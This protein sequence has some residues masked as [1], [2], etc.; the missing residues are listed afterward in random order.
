MASTE[1][2]RD[3]YLGRIH[4][5]TQFTLVGNTLNATN[6][7]ATTVTASGY[8]GGS[9]VGTTVSGTVAQFT[10]V[11]GST[12][13]GST[14]LFTTLTASQAFVSG[15]LSVGDYIQMLP[16]GNIAIP[17]NQT[18]SYIYTS[19]STNDIYFTQ[20][21]PG[22]NLTNTT[23]LR[24]LEGS[25]ST[26]LLHGGT[27]STVNG[28]T[29]FNV[30]SGSG[31]IVSYNAST[32]TDPYPTIKYI[33]W[34][35]FVSQSLIYS[36]SAQI[37]YVAIDEFGA[38]SQLN[39]AFTTA[40]FK[41]RIILGRVLHQ[42]GSVTNGTIS[43]PTTAYAISSNTQDFFRAFGPLKVSGQILAAS[44]S[45]LGLTRTAGDSYVEGRNYSA[46]PNSPNFILAA[47][48]PALTTT[49]IF[50]EWVSGSTVNIDTNGGVGYTAVKPAFYNLNGT[51]TAISPTN[52][53]YTVQRVYWFPKSV[54]RAL[55]V[56]YGSTI[57]TTLS[58]AVAAINNEPNFI[59][60]DNT[61]TSAVYIGAIVLEANTTDLTV[62]SKAQ[63][64]NG[65]LFRGA[66]G[67]GGG[68]GGGTTS[69][70]GVNHAIQF[71]DASTFNGSSNFTFDTTTL[72]LNG[73]FH[74]VG[75][76]SIDFDGGTLTGS[77]ARFTTMSGSVITGSTALYTTI[78]GSTITGSTALF[79]TIT[80]STVT[81]S[82]ALFTNITASSL[83]ADLATKVS[84]AGD[85]MTG[86]L[87]IQSGG[88]V[89]TGNSAFAN[90]LGIGAT[91]TTTFDIYQPNGAF[92]AD[93]RLRGNGQSTT[94]FDIA[95]GINGHY[96]YGYGPAPMDFATSGS[97]RLRIASTGQITMSNGVKVQAGGI[98]VTGQS[99]ILGNVGIGATPTTQFDVY[100]GAG[101]N[102]NVRV[103]GNAGTNTL[104]IAAGSAAHY[105]YGYSSIP[106]QFA[107]N[108]VNRF[109]LYAGGNANF[110]NSLGLGSVSSPTARIH[111]PAGTATAG[112]APLKFTSGT[113]L[114][115]PESGS[116]EYD[117]SNLYFTTGSVRESI[118]AK[119]ARAGDTMTGNLIITGAALGINRSGG[120]INATDLHI[121]AGNISID[122][123]VSTRLEPVV[124]SPGN[125][126]RTLTFHP[127]YTGN[128]GV[129]AVALQTLPEVGA[130]ASMPLLIGML[131][132]FIGTATKWIGVYVTPGGGSATTNY[133]AI[134]NGG[135]NVGIGLESPTA[136]LH[137]SGGNVRID[138]SLG[139]NTSPTAR[140]HLPAGTVTAG[141]APLK[142]TA[143]TNLTSPESGSMEYDGNNLYFTTGSVRE[144]ISAK[145]ARAGDTM[146]GPL[147]INYNGT[148]LNVRNTASNGIGSLAVV[149]KGNGT[150]YSNFYLQDENGYP[151]GHLWSFSMRNDKSFLFFSYGGAF[152]NVM[153]LQQ[154]GGI[155]VGNSF[156]TST[157]VASNV[158][159]SSLNFGAGLSAPT[160]RLHISGGS[161]T[162]GTAPLKFNSG[163]LLT[164]PESGSMEYDGNELYFTTGSVRKT[165]DYRR[166]V[167]S[168]IASHTASVG[169][170]VI[171]SGSFTITLPS[172]STSGNGAEIVVKKTS[173]GA[174]TITI[175]ASVGTIDGATTASLT[176]QY[177]SYTFASDGSTNWWII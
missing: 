160:A 172:P 170:C 145:V 158:F 57:Y 119:V 102:A 37:T 94:V 125:Y 75:T 48:D 28:T 123:A 53:K 171:A 3:K 7:N 149:G 4:G 77:L 117:G 98:D 44:G 128:T 109:T 142:F 23:R 31:I 96:L 71:N 66:G 54:T 118:S 130:G 79:T 91:P 39:S 38:I 111:L 60:G 90:W 81:G 67:G 154:N 26:G 168:S 49:K 144:S 24:W 146:T 73:D 41:D 12:L 17:T 122:G 6:V 18:A 124:S 22:T 129:N 84:K 88:L 83:T 55:Y 121:G 176:T 134:F 61:R 135:G 152:V 74:L 99:Q 105:I 76:G 16:V 177:S 126:A 173:T 148:G 2:E 15:G 101:S 45:T 8:S 62:S 153:C 139:I 35:N 112:T 116:F 29:T 127:K 143:G 20:Y 115:T 58:E 47:D 132:A 108:G 167:T 46:N 113:N 103:R 140:I 14:A 30:A 133:D 141:T 1:Y 13:T 89:V 95:S 59:E 161:A 85:T 19:G 32:T 11:S 157:T 165:I 162:A 63:I 147:T 52:N 114:T 151:S 42:T 56:Y 80:G 78:T 87:T 33:Q 36:G 68:G 159:A 51:V 25:L 93:F 155:R 43:T 138:S 10:T 175:S 136:K 70:G 100:A 110:A 131:S 65:G 166:F 174:S 104:D 64:V 69:P 156:A 34:N 72:T 27:L 92:N 107:T 163:P 82:T 5:K 97:L 150:E 120:A 106:M 40:Q 9:F 21:Q 86:G 169:S 50:Y 164:S 137:V